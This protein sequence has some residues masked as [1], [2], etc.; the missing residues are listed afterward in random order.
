MEAMAAT[1]GNSGYR[2]KQS[3]RAVHDHF[4]DQD[5]IMIAIKVGKSN[6]AFAKLSFS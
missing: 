6:L 1:F 5:I 4:L 3:F 2:Q